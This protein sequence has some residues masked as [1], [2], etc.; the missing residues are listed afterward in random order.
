M[1]A[2]LFIALGCMIG[3]FITAFI[4][5]DLFYLQVSLLTYPMYMG[6]VLTISMIKNIKNK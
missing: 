4:P 1:K 5:K 3:L 6:I 2:N